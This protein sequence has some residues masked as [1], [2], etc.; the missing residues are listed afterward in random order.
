MSSGDITVDMAKPDKPVIA[1]NT[2]DP[3]KNDVEVAITTNE[4]QGKI[5]YRLGQAGWTSYTGKFSVTNNTTVYARVYDL[6]G[7]VSEEAVKE[8]ANID[9][10]APVITIAGVE[11]GQIYNKKVNPVISTDDANATITATLNGASYD[12]KSPISEGGT[13]SLKVVAIDKAGNSS[14]KAINFTIDATAPTIIINGVEDGKAY[15][16]DVKPEIIVNGK[17]CTVKVLLNDKPF[18]SGDKIT[19]EGSYVLKVVVT[20]GFGKQIPVEKKFTID[21]TAPVITVEGVE[22]GKIY[23]GT[24]VVV[25]AKTSEAAKVTAVLDEKAYTLGTSIETLGDHKLTV[26]AVDNAGNES[27]KEIRFSLQVAIPKDADKAAEIVKDLA[28]KQDKVVINGTENPVLDAKVL[29]ALKGVDKPVSITVESQ[30]ITLVWTF[31]G[32]DIKDA[33]KSVDLSL[34]AAAP[35]KD[36]ITKV[37]S[38][39]QIISF[40]NHGTLPA[41]MTITIPVDTKKFDV[42]KPLYFYYYNETTKKAELIADNLKAYQKGDAYFVDVTIT[43]CSDYFL[44]ASD[45]KT[46]L[47]KVEKLVQT[48]SPV[49]MNVLVGLGILLIGTGFVVV[50]ARRRKRT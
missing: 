38:N 45:S 19:A 26:T 6:A 33:S 5:E 39:A 35:N 22:D 8:I 28:T 14:D 50:L 32:K 44:S 16:A 29:E 23:L 21:K 40:K 1:V 30:G 4:P 34:N 10:I 11:N 25:N 41:P 12:G 31:N 46:V 49:D 47:P 37:D 17:E 7:N 36:L 2:E 24:S 13:Y 48:G 42:T 27:K 20:D 3:T 9:R 18:N 43:H 15:K